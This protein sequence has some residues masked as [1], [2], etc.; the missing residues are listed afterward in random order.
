VYI[1]PF[2]KIT[3]ACFCHFRNRILRF[4][5]VFVMK[6]GERFEVFVIGAGVVGSS[7]AMALAERGLKALAVDIDLSGR[8]SS[9]EKNAAYRA[10]AR[11]RP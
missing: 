7:I 4:C 10:S 5:R 6:K 2:E 8:L 1:G 9:S 11:T 3:Y